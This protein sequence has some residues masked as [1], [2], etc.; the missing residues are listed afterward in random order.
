MRRGQGLPSLIIISI[1]A[2]VIHLEILSESAEDFDCH[3][4]GLI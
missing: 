1:Q 3:V 2:Q 4:T